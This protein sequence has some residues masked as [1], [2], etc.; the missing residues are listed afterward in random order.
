MGNPFKKSTPQGSG[1]QEAKV[2]ERTKGFPLKASGT[3]SRKGKLDNHT[4][5][6]AK[7]PT[8]G[9]SGGASDLKLKNAKETM[10]LSPNKAVGHGVSSKDIATGYSKVK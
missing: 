7:Y 6:Q 2:T 8:G 10:H 4:D 9:K 3:N 1:S 5:S